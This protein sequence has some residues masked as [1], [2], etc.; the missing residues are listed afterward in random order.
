MDKEFLI[1]EAIRPHPPMFGSFVPNKTIPKKV[2]FFRFG[3]KCVSMFLLKD[4]SSWINLHIHTLILF[5][6]K[7]KSCLNFKFCLMRQDFMVPGRNFLQD[8]PESGRWKNLIQLQVLALLGLQQQLQKFNAAFRIKTSEVLF[9]LIF[10]SAIFIFNHHEYTTNQ[11]T[12]FQW[13]FDI[14]MKSE[15]IKS[16]MDWNPIAWGQA[17]PCWEA[18]WEG[19]LKLSPKFGKR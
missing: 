2:W 1:G 5:H 7:Q 18:R 6:V 8:L 14:S 12:S 17:Q 10:F 13:L 9:V 4:D 11:I 3:I 19:K 15:K 16:G